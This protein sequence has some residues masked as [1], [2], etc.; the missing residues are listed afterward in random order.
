M[1]LGPLEGEKVSMLIHTYPLKPLRKN[2]VAIRNHQADSQIYVWPDVWSDD[3]QVI[4]DTECPY[5][6]QVSLNNNLNLTPLGL[7]TACLWQGM[8]FEEDEDITV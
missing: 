1:P 2:E 5:W 8:N 3:L 7:L 4:H 6:D